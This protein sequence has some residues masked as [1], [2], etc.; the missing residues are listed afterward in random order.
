[1]AFDRRTF[2]L[3][4]GSRFLEHAIETHGDVVVGDHA[5]VEYGLD[6]PT[7]IY[8]GDG[9]T[10]LG[11]LT[12]GGDV[13]ADVFC[14]VD[15]EVNAQGSA[16]LGEGVHITG[17][18]S[19]EEDLDV[20]D[21]VTLEEGFEARGWINIRSPVPTVVYVVIYVLQMMRQGKSEEVQRILDEL[22]DAEET[23]QVSET[24]CFVPNGSHLGLQQSHI[25]GGMR[26]GSD[27]RI[28]GNFQVEEDTH[29]GPSSELH[30]SLRVQGDV[31]LDAMTEV[32]GDLEAWGEVTIG[33]EAVVH[34]SIEARRVDIWE[35][36]T[37][38]GTIKAPEGV[39]FRTEAAE[40]MEQ[41][42]QDFQ[43]GVQPITEL[44]EE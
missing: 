31:T 4:D 7:S 12:A 5:R 18:L 28:L 43:D 32:H 23:F 38:R 27:C 34:G 29:V 6:T 39:S 17:R 16:W 20:G 11:D 9:V 33:K 15:G 36:A 44:L 26:T 37:V 30:G 19:V 22:D 14:E 24:F 1:M 8:L 21:E 42:V 3:P 2:V 10:V 13:R 35:S 25:K 40:E 41:K